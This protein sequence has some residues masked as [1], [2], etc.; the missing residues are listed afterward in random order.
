MMP[1]YVELLPKPAGVEM[2]GIYWRH[3]PGDV[4]RVDRV[5][6]PGYYPESTWVV[7]SRDGHEITEVSPKCFKPYHGDPAKSQFKPRK[8]HQPKISPPSTKKATSP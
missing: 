1:R 5:L 4:F 3:L 7:F 8:Y 6:P 2:A